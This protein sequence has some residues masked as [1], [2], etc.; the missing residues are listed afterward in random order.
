[1]TQIQLELRFDHETY[2]TALMPSTMN[3]LLVRIRRDGKFKNQLREAL[4]VSPAEGDSTKKSD[5][6]KVTFDVGTTGTHIYMRTNGSDSR[7]E[8]TREKPFRTLERAWIEAQKKLQSNEKNVVVHGVYT[9]K[10]LYASES[11]TNQDLTKDFMEFSPERIAG[12]DLVSETLD[13]HCRPVYL[14]RTPGNAKLE[15]TRL[16]SLLKTELLNLNLKP[17]TTWHYDPSLRI[18]RVEIL[19][20]DQ[21]ID[22]IDGP[23]DDEYSPRRSDRPTQNKARAPVSG[24]KLYDHLLSLGIGLEV[25]KVYISEMTS[26][27]HDG[28]GGI[29]T[30]G[31][32]KASIE[33]DALMRNVKHQGKLSGYYMSMILAA[34][35]LAG[36]GLVYNNTVIIVASMLVSPLMGPILTVTFGMVLRDAKMTLNGLWTEIVGLAF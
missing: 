34:G 29:F 33:F 3:E 12:M 14:F 24:E 30:L 4:G 2:A 17:F 23:E 15:L 11:G 5:A 31:G 25:G 7:G 32:E 28:G 27:V 10:R 22:D 8:G 20:P 13:D 35:T 16:R 6:S 19:C 1:M 9:G 18:N 21:V 36:F 26:Y